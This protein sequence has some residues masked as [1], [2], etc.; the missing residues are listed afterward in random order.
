MMEKI[1]KSLTYCDLFG[2]QLSINYRDREVYKSVTGGLVS[3]IFLIVLIIF[4]WNSILDFVNRV[5]VDVT[6]SKK[7]SINPDTMALSYPNWMMAF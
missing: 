3:L 4:F 1:K 2:K 7:Y 6:T 5:N